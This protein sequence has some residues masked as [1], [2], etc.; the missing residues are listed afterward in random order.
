MPVPAAAGFG[1]PA[2]SVHT[3]C[4]GLL[5]AGS[6]ELTARSRFADEWIAQLQAPITRVFRF[7]NSGHNSDA[8]EP[9]RF[10]DIMIDTVLPET[11]RR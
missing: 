9:D 1:L 8:E 4:A 10:N 5:H 6:T 11:Y 7:E 3:G 2:H